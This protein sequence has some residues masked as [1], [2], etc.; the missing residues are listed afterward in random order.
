MLISKVDAVFLSILLWYGTESPC[1]IDWEVESWRFP[2]GFLISMNVHGIGKKCVSRGN[3]VGLNK[4][5]F[6]DTSL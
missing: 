4:I 1:P 6:Y 5:E 2:H 3:F